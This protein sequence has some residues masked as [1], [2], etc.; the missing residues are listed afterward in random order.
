VTF[1]YGLESTG[2]TIN[3]VKSAFNKQLQIHL[4][5]NDNNP[6]DPSLRDTPEA[7]LQGAHRL[8]RGRYFISKCDTLSNQYSSSFSWV[9]KEV[10]NVGH[11]REGMSNFAANELY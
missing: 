9:K 10:P 7:N 1:P 3:K 6:N 4:G 2:L 11:D 8:D 5:Q